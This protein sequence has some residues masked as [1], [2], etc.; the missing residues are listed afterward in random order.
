ML[1][2]IFSQ[3]ANRQ[4]KVWSRDQGSNTWCC[5]LE[6]NWAWATFY[7]FFLAYG[8][9][10]AIAPSLNQY[11]QE[12]IVSAIQLL[13]LAG[14]QVTLGWVAWKYPHSFK[15]SVK[16]TSRD[17]FVYVSLALLLLSLT[18]DRLKFS[19][20]SDELSYA[21]SAHGHAFYLAMAAARHLDWLDDYEFSYLVQATSFLLFAATACLLYV[22]RHWTAKRRI[23][24][25]VILLVLGRFVFA[26]KG[27][28]GSPHPPLQLL[29]PFVFGSVIGINDISFK[30]SYFLVYVGFLT[31]LCRMLVRV[32]PLTIAYVATLTIGT[33]PLLLNTSSVVEHSFWSFICFALVFTEILTSTKK[34]YFRLVGVI[35]IMTMMRQPSFLALL[36]V[37]ILYVIEVIKEGSIKQKVGDYIKLISLQLL[38]IPFLASS[39]IKG[40]PSTNAWDQGSNTERVVQAVENGVIWDSLSAAFPIWWLIFIPLSFIPIQRKYWDINIAMIVFFFAAIYVYYSIHPGLWGLAKYQVEYAAPLVIAGFIL[41]NKVVVI[42]NTNK[43][44]ILILLFS[45]L[46]LNVLQ[47]S[48][49]RY[50]TNMQNSFSRKENTKSEDEV[51]L[52]KMG[53]T[54]IPYEYKKAYAYIEQKRLSE[55]TYSIGATYGILPEIMNGYTTKAV[56]AS[57]D[58]YTG[59]LSNWLKAGSSEIDVDHIASDSRIKAVILGSIEKKQELITLLNVR[60]W[61][62][63]ASFANPQYGTSVVIMMRP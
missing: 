22:S 30:L 15:D 13:M 59:Q 28:N 34:R 46:I 49:Q 27:G 24:V 63:V 25:F 62:K 48:E 40:T 42:N 5:V 51:D 1:A 16:V 21:G 29:P 11:K 18:Q 53:M 33:L 47:L 45:L 20:F 4:R 31:L 26:I 41:I 61:Q 14:V 12:F 2:A 60:G 57:Q 7:A 36:P 19:L 54:A 44:I 10:G 32:Y 23:V 8:Y 52:L 58:I 38:F 3:W 9:Y 6:I 35:S 56:K 17:L 43:K 55:N 37:F 50:A 39:L